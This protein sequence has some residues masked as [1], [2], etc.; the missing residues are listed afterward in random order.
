MNETDNRSRRRAIA[1][2]V[3]LLGPALLAG[4]VLLR[5]DG[6]GE[7]ARAEG[8]AELAQQVHNLCAACHAYPPPESFPRS[9]W[10]KEVHQGYEFAAEFRPDLHRPAVQAVIDYFQSRAPERLETPVPATSSRPPV[11]FRQ[12][13]DGQGLKPHSI[14][15]VNLVR[16]FDARRPEILACDM[17]ANVVKLLRP[18]RPES[19]WEVLAKVPHPAHTEVVDLDG[20]GVKDILV[21]CLGTFPPSDDLFGK[22]VWLRGNPSG[23]FTPVTLL[24]GVGRVADVRAADFNGDGKLDLVVGVFGWRRTG[25]LLLL[26]NRTT[27]WAKPVF[28]PRQVDPRHGTSHV[29]VADLNND[30]RPDFIAL[31]S[32]EHETVVAFINEGG[33][34]FRQEVVFTAPHPA[35]G[36]SGIELTNLDG[37]GDLDVLYTA[38]DSLDNPSLI[39]PEHGV[40][41]LENR[42]GFPF[43]NRKLATLPGAHRAVPAD[44]DGDGDLDVVAVS[45]LPREFVAGQK[46]HDAVLFLEQVAPGRFERHSLKRGGCDHA[47]VAAGDLSG[48]GRI[49][50]VTGNFAFFEKMDDS[51]TIWR[52][53]GKRANPTLP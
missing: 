41:L 46:D 15:N 3:L 32:Q 14:S 25:S 49:D 9:A 29:P 5:R 34:R 40:Y 24:E 28:V 31:I 21:A 8:E 48:E 11:E 36:S 17:Q 42:G 35:F 39:R 33:F 51:V 1:V 27:D 18:Y 44:L 16:L 53:R 23:G 47:T 50:F 26:E 12:V 38:G 52:N 37:D 7:V 20:D 45:L 2:T 10:E 22:V 43:V 13:G 30:G 4:V 19:S 6:A